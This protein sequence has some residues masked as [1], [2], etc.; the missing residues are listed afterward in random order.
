M[1]S[2]SIYLPS[3]KY[4]MVR[5]AV[6]QILCLLICTDPPETRGV[7]RSNA[8]QCFFH[9]KP[10]FNVRAAHAKRIGIAA[11][12]C[13]ISTP[14]ERV[15]TVT[16]LQGLRTSHYGFSDRGLPVLFFDRGLP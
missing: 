7:F 12:K 5:R 1:I 4:R 16:L 6:S 9:E 11:L 15:W 2:I 14:F 10:G 8:K 13:Y 3:V